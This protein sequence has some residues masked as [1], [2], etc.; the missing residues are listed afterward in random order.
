MRTGATSAVGEI[1]H[2]EYD[3]MMIIAG[4]WR[5]G[6]WRHVATG[7]NALVY[8]QKPNLIQSDIKFIGGKETT[9]YIAVEVATCYGL[10][11]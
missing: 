8:H 6:D 7:C 3:V 11:M 10:P 9:T 1:R 5:Y 4:L 2:N